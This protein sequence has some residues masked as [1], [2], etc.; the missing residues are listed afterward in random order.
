M[1]FIGK[2]PTSGFSTIVKDDLTPDGST[3]AF[4]LSKNVAS[5]NDIAVFVGNVRQEPTDAYSVSGTTLT[6]TAAPASGLNF[7]VLHIAGTVES[8]V[9]PAAGTTV[10]GAFGVSG[11]LDVDGTLNVSDDLKFIGGATPQFGIGT[12]T[13]N[14][15]LH[16]YGN[17]ANGAEI[18]LTN[19]DMSVDRRTQNFFMSGD[20]ATWRLLN[21]AGT[22]GGTSVSL[23]WD[24]ILD[25]AAFTG[26]SGTAYGVL[27]SHS[28][29]DSN[30]PYGSWGTPN[31]TYYRWVLP[32]AGTYELYSEMRIRIWG[33][34]GLI[35]SRLY[36]NT[37]S[38]VIDEIGGGTSI[39]MDMEDANNPNGHLFN[40]Q[41]S[42][43]WIVQTTADNQD[44]HHQMNSNNNSTSTSVQSDSN[45][46]NMHM[47]KRIG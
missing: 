38:S 23:D 26:T 46:W 39:R 11:N 30:V 16:V 14:R 10:P 4:T 1:P 9:V 44:I 19:T 24:G 13:P 45:G 5:A 37:T 41:V 22:A 7:Y 25:A 17:N 12:L 33:V 28:I 47:W 31:S 3:T 21:D 15:K 32:K 36:N 8:S 20:K 43:R 40:V 27:Y 34:A 29:G 2:N 42:H 6:M 35:Q 18:S